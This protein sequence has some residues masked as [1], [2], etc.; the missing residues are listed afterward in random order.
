MRTAALKKNGPRAAQVVESLRKLPAVTSAEANLLTGSVT[1]HYDR[2]KADLGTLE[3][4]LREHCG[5]SADPLPDARALLSTP[6]PSP[7]ALRRNDPRA[8][9]LH[10]VARTAALFLVEKAVEQALLALL[11]GLL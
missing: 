10:T 7:A 9:V 11:A 5:V 6:A 3:L 2:T 8:K 4:A 1:I